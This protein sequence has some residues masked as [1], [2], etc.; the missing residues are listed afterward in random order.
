MLSEDFQK[1]W[2]YEFELVYSVILSGASL[3]TQLQVNNKSSKSFEFQVLTHTY[4]RI[5][6]FLANSL[7]LNLLLNTQ[8]HW[9]M[10][11]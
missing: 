6:V 10:K 8:I 1:A 5:E 9:K 2:S 11:F 3:E 7:A 4:L